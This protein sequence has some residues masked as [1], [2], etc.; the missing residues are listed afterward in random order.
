[1]ISQ[2]VVLAKYLS[3]AT[4]S[5]QK[6][7]IIV[8]WKLLTPNTIISSSCTCSPFSTFHSIPSQ[9][10]MPS[11]IVS[12]NLLSYILQNPRPALNLFPLE[13]AS[14]CLISTV[15]IFPQAFKM[16]STEPKPQPEEAKE[17]PRPSYPGLR[18]PEVVS[19]ISWRSLSV[20]AAVGGL[21]LGFMFFIKREKELGK[22]LLFSG[23]SNYRELKV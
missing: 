20:A 13:K 15:F 6:S 21:L 16:Y 23:L 1:M 14:L 17:K 8:K 2:S 19:P 4:R 7:G 11:V 5:V 18:K 10:R 12:T 22:V 3:V 9:I